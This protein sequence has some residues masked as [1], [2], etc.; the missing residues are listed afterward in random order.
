[1]KLKSQSLRISAPDWVALRRQTLS[2]DGLESAGVL[3]CG[4]SETSS[5]RHLLAKRFVPVPAECYRERTE[6]H[7]EVEPEFYNDAVDQALA[8]GLTP[9]VVHSHPFASGAHYSTSDDFGES[10]LLPVLAA[11]L[12]GAAPASLLVAPDSVS[13]RTLVGRDFFPLHSVSIVGQRS[14]VVEIDRGGRGPR[15]GSARVDRQIRAIGESGQSL[16]EK[17]VVG[18]VGLGG[19]GSIV[20]ELLARIGVKEF[21]LVDPDRVEESN[22]SRLFGSVPRSVG[23]PKV[24]VV[25]DYLSKIGVRKIAA[26]RESAT[27][28]STLMRLRDADVVFGCVDNDLTRSILNRFAVQYLIPLLDMGIRLDARGG[29]VSAAAGRV[30]VVGHGMV[31]LQCAGH[32]DPERIR[33]ESLPKRE[34]Q[35]LAK[36]GYVIGVDEPAPAVASLNG[37]VAS[38][39]VT[40][41]INL[42][43]NLTGG[44]QPLDQLYDATSGV[45]FTAEVLHREGCDVCDAGAGVKA[46]GDKQIVSAYE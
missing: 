23:D 1:M 42:F 36:E 33:A 46:L 30:S 26:H 2:E 5:A 32:L 28:Q 40:A 8:D 18:I 6:Y 38:L 17:L 15:A 22:I 43:V 25:R 45:V 31:C 16:L 41:A 11:L 7:L 29:D 12:P 39:A 13:G 27:R 3:L 34:R 35:A 10:R 21:V 24:E 37:T 14:Q 44:A 20:A 19:T 9:V 4:V